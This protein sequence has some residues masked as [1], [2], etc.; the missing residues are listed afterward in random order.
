MSKGAVG[1]HA[2]SV[3]RIPTVTL[4]PAHKRWVDEKET[5]NEMSFVLNL[6]ECWCIGKWGSDVVVSWQVGN[7]G[8]WSTN[9]SK[10]VGTCNLTK[11]RYVLDQ[12]TKFWW[13]FKEYSTMNRSNWSTDFE[14]KFWLHSLGGRESRRA[15]GSLALYC[16]ILK[17]NQCVW[18]KSNG[19]DKC[20]NI[21][22]DLRYCNPNKIKG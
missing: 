19:A 21:A 14:H 22:K 9:N 18:E 11:T 3:A 4:L 10:R 7:C 2:V 1:C 15:E 17:S 5:A 16:R 13:Q 20:A 6:R 12:W 8:R